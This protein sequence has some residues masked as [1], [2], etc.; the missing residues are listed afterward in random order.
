MSK[1][2]TPAEIV[3]TG[4]P[5]VLVTWDAELMR[6]AVFEHEQ[7]EFMLSAQLAS[8]LKR[9]DRCFSC[10]DSRVLGE[11]GLPF[12]LDESDEV[13]T[14]A[15]RAASRKLARRVKGWWHRCVSE[16][17][18]ADLQ[19]WAILMGLAVGELAWAW[20]KDGFIYPRMHVH[21]MQHVRWDPSRKG[22]VLLTIKGPIPITPGDGRWVL[23]APAGAARPWLSGAVRALALPTLLRQA[24]RRDWADRS[25]LEG[26]GIRKA[27]MPAG[28][29]DPDA[30]AFIRQLKKLGR[31]SIVALQGDFDFSIAVADMAA[32]TGFE[33]LVGHCDTAITLTILGQNLTTQIEGGSFAAATV[34]ARV[35]RD[36]LESDVA[37][38]S[39]VL[40]DQVLLPW[41][42]LNIPD[43]AREILPWPSWDTTPPEDQ[44]KAAQAILTVSQA[45]TAL[46]A[47]GVNL[48]PILERFELELDPSASTE[49]QQDPNA[50]DQKQ[51]DPAAGDASASLK[52][53]P[54]T[55]HLR[56]RR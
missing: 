36:R 18:L 46:K 41:C 17:Q 1:P 39:T 35:L 44:Q 52:R 34:H 40:R 24:C 50:V 4:E 31:K 11:L 53:A 32:Q 16:A 20:D 45:I 55:A 30:K 25:E 2:I 9:D 26:T 43:F 23:F 7:G 27:K 12:A 29:K 37:M 8:S 33:K 51:E 48:T 28:T 6:S 15:L 22:L 10:L 56:R 3:D 47:A 21:D 5:D 49:P 38:L 14:K 42:L 13:E 19:T 54:R